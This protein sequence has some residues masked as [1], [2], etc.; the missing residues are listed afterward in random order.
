MYINCKKKRCRTQF[1]SKNTTNNDLGDV[2]SPFRAVPFT[3]AKKM[4][5]YI[6]VSPATLPLYL[7]YKFQCNNTTVASRIYIYIYVY[8]ISYRN[9]KPYKQ[10]RKMK[11]NLGAAKNTGL[12]CTVPLV[13]VEAPS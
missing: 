1:R 7:Q 8:Y 9:M 4:A 3:N 11:D 6:Y 5:A 12:P 2:R 13:I 10:N